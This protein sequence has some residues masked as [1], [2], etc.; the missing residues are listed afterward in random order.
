MG[1]VKSESQVCVTPSEE[2]EV[3]ITWI[4]SMEAGFTQVKHK[5]NVVLKLCY[6]LMFL[7]VNFLS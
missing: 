5:A 2:M 3:K 7:E 4:G 6:L 1:G